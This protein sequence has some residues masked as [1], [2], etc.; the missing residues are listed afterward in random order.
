M[1][2]MNAW[3][4]LRW[5]LVFVAVF[6]FLV[7]LVVDY[8]HQPKCRTLRERLRWWRRLMWRCAYWLS[9]VVSVWCWLT[10]GWVARFVAWEHKNRQKG[11]K[12]NERPKK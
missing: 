10:A 8:F 1:L 11:G 2:D 3:D 9:F 5:V 7:E 4:I 6:A 12:T